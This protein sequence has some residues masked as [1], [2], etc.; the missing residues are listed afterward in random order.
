VVNTA[1]VAYTTWNTVTN[2]AFRVVELEPDLVLVYDS[3]NDFFVRLRPV[4]CYDAQDP[5]CGLYVGQWRESFDFDG[6]G[7]SAFYRY[8]GVR[9]GWI[10]NPLVLTNWLIPLA[11]YYPCQGTALSRADILAANPPVY[12]ERNLRSLAGLARVHGIQIVFSSWA[13]YPDDNYFSEEAR[14]ALAE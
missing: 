7:W 4:E 6:M 11:D 3:V 13:Y 2:F 8:L 10:D 14:Q 5:T 9:L 12:F 1:A